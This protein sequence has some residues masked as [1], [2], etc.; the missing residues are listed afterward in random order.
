[1]KPS[2]CPNKCEKADQNREIGRLT[3]LRRLIPRPPAVTL[4]TALAR[5]FMFV[6]VVFVLARLLAALLSLARLPE[7]CALSLRVHIR[8]HREA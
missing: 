2:A 7:L 6:L 3:L 8:A 4:L 1:M 5:L